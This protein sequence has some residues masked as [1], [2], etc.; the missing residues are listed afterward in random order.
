MSTSSN[1]LETKDRRKDN[2]VERKAGLLFYLPRILTPAQPHC[3][4]A[5]LDTSEESNYLSG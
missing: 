1:R 2:M 5:P 4:T 3:L